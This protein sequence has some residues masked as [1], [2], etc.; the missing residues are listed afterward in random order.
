M[1][2][3]K[4]I[5]RS[6]PLSSFTNVAPQGGAAIW[7][8]ISQALD[9]A[10][11]MVAPAAKAEMARMG[12][13]EG[14]R[15]AQNNIGRTS[16]QGGGGSYRDAIASIESA[17]SGDY[18]AVGPTTDKGNRAYG[19]YQV[20]DFNVGNWTEKYTGRR[21]TPQEFL[22]DPGAQDA[23]FDGE[24]GAS[25]E[26]YGNP[27]D[28][29]SVWFSGRPMAQAGNS[30]DGYNTVPQY[31]QKFNSYLAANPVGDAPT[32]VTTS[33]GKIEP[34]MYSPLS[35]PV[36]QAHNAAAQ[37][38]Y[39]A[40]V[41]TQAT[42]DLQNLS[43]GF[44]LNPDGFDAAAQDYID[45]IVADAPVEF[46]GALRSDL[47]NAAL[48]RYT[49]LMSEKQTDIRRRAI[50]SN[51]ALSDRYAQ[52]YAELRAAGDDEGALAV[53]EQL[54]GVLGARERLPGASWTPE[55][56]TNVFADAE[57]SAV[58]LMQRNATARSNEAKDTLGTIIDAAQSG[59]VAADEEI[60]QDP[61]VQSQ[62]PDLV[63]EAQ[64]FIGLREAMP[65]FMRM[66]PAMMDQAIAEARQQPV[67]DDFEIDVIKAAEKAAKAS[68]KAWEDDPILQAQTVMDNKPPEVQYT[69][70][71]EDDFVEG[72][73][74]RRQYGLTLHSEGYTDRP[75]FFS[76]EEADV[77]S[78]LLSKE[79]DPAIRAA[80][81]GFLAEGL[82]PD[83]IAAFDQ[84][85][86]DDVTAFGGK[87]AAM[88]APSVAAEAMLGQQYLD[89]GVVKAPTEKVQRE[90]VSAAVG[91]AFQ[92][93][94]GAPEHMGE[95]MGFATALYASQAQGMDPTSAAA[96]TLM[97][98]SM[99]RAM[100]QTTNS[101]G[102]LVGGVQEILGG[103]TILPPHVSGESANA[104]LQ[105]SLGIH[106]D[107]GFAGNLIALPSRVGARVLGVDQGP[108]VE[109]WQAAASMGEGQGGSIPLFNGKPIPD[110]FFTSGAVRV[111]AAG[112]SLY[113]MEI[114]SGEATFPAEDAN[115]NVLFFD[116]EKLMEAMR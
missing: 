34:R 32:V 114:G 21:M 36:L 74:A 57:R 82:G 51:K 72:L 56:T 8:G 18:G 113:R 79:T 42:V 71:A 73:K 23:V 112:G 66:P 106:P 52:E 67:E 85:D 70:G 6:N 90:V 97:E 87:M 107:L 12:D 15:A 68:R 60:L 44:P 91:N 93:I 105:A 84:L 38:A 86:V 55:Q 13:E 20:M 31:I 47:S 89:E 63:A 39:A 27:Q 102:Q 109:A 98:E 62:L 94:P 65:D 101:R 58:R 3:L 46:R 80:V 10:Y 59:M 41:S 22:A 96:K 2:T 9:A 88:G 49:G 37:A 4:K 61:W 99:Q 33:E 54:Q 75:T 25:V 14:R 69:P 26:R 16:V 29:A 103:K 115:G 48:R 7:G 100:G 24:F 110:K 77:L 95:I 111:V 83:A 28:A 92:G 5:V 53:A 76:Q 116:L 35:G 17:G 108:N 104:M 45:Q 64:A 78:G 19:R 81:S 43:N 50:N 1:A 40:E 11:D 30:S